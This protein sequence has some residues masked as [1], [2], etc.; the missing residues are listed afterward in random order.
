M[1]VEG[2]PKFLAQIGQHKGKRAARVL[3]SIARGER[4]EGGFRS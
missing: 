2:E 4:I 3:R 1:M